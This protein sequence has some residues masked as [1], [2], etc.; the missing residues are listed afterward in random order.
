MSCVSRSSEIRMTGEI[1]KPHADARMESAASAASASTRRFISAGGAHIARATFVCTSASNTPTSTGSAMIF[2]HLRACAQATSL[3]KKEQPMP[4]TTDPSFRP[5]GPKTSNGC[6][7]IS[8]V[9]DG[10]PSTQTPAGRTPETACLD[11]SFT[12]CKGTAVHGRSRNLRH[13]YG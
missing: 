11:R 6:R 4:F 10:L 3:F 8:T 9:V 2:R 7:C 1:S 12:A 13:F 5:F